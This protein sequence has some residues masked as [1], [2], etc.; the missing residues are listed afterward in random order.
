VELLCEQA[1][2]ETGEVTANAQFIASELPANI[3]V[4]AALGEPEVII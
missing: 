3:E 2:V 4:L 1:E